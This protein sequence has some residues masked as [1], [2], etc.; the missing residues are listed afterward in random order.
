MP[1]FLFSLSLSLIDKTELET[2]TLSRF[3]YQ[4][5]IHMLTTHSS[6]CRLGLIITQAS[7][8]EC[9][10]RDVRA[11]MREDMLMLNDDKTEFL[12]IGTQR[13]SSRYL[14][15]TS[16]LANLKSP[17]YTRREI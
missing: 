15:G 2:L 6:T 4:P 11:W 5:L 3:I 12:I 17:W 14:S 8:I 10:I 7:W 1:L 9:C 13:Q 16:R